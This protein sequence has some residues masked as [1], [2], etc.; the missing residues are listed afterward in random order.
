MTAPVDV[1]KDHPVA[2]TTVS[3]TSLA[4][5][6][7]WLAGHLGVPLSAEAGTVIGG[8]LAVVAAFI[9]REGILGFWRILLHGKK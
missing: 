4:V 2:V 6:V 8:A 1:A 3:T 5:G 7:V 9:G